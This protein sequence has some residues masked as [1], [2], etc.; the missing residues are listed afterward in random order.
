M[1]KKVR[2][3]SMFVLMFVLVVLMFPMATFANASAEENEDQ[4]YVLQSGEFDCYTDSEYLYDSTTGSNDENYSVYDYAEHLEELYP[5]NSL[6][7]VEDTWLLKVIPEVLFQNEGEYFCISEKSDGYQQ[8]YVWYDEHLEF[9]KEIEHYPGAKNTNQEY[10]TWQ[11][12]IP[13][14][15]VM[16]VGVMDIKYGARGKNDNTW[17]SHSVSVKCYLTNEYSED[18]Y[19]GVQE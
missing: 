7:E 12:Y 14:S 19:G 16:N 13:K 17:Y 6:A 4:P 2:K 1:A 5:D 18:V 9:V 15:K 3:I 10:Y 11:M 8:I